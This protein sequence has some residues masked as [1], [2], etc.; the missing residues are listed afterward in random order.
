M[1]AAL[2]KLRLNDAINAKRPVLL[3]LR[4]AHSLNIL[5]A[6]P[7]TSDTNGPF[8]I[9]GVIAIDGTDPRTGTATVSSEN[10]TSLFVE[11]EKGEP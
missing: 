7:V 11:H 2:L 3:L 6:N 9:A 1:E 8:D 10:V 5:R 4:G